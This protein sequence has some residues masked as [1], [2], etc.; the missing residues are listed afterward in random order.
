MTIVMLYILFV[1][2]KIYRKGQYPHETQKKVFFVL[3]PRIG[4][5]VTNIPCK[6]FIYIFHYE[7]AQLF[8][9]FLNM[10]ACVLVPDDVMHPLQ[11]SHQVPW[12]DNCVYHCITH[13]P[14]IQQINYPLSFVISYHL[15]LYLRRQ[16]IEIKIDK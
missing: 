11:R 9:T 1:K 4:N 7:N 16:S 13:V 12:D 6:G 3:F 8:K 15:D 5:S 10:I 14:F 2:N